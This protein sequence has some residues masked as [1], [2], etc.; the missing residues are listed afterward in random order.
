M[1]ITLDC[2]P[3][4]VNS[5]LRLLKSGSIPE[6]EKEP[7]MRHLLQYLADE[8]YDQSPPDMA[9]EMHQ[10]IRKSEFRGSLS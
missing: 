7:A 9:R 1:N 6:S 10:M 4:T 5:F 3:C 8:N 2:I